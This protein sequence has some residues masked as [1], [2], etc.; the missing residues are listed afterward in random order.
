MNDLEIILH[1]TVPLNPVDANPLASQ[2]GYSLADNA[3]AFS[4]TSRYLDRYVDG[5]R[6]VEADFYCSENGLHAVLHETI[7]GIKSER[8]K[9]VKKPKTRKFERHA[10]ASIDSPN[11]ANMD[12]FIDLMDEMATKLRENY[13]KKYNATLDAPVGR[14]LVSTIFV[15]NVYT[16]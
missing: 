4:H 16:N 14:L 5:N 10:V 6:V 2:G 11:V 3:A 12:D 7:Y 15:P 8:S 1:N 9:R 13:L